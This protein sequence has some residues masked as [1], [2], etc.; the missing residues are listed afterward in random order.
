[1]AGKRRTRGIVSYVGMEIC[2][3]VR[4][5]IKNSASCVTSEKRVV[6]AGKEKR[7]YLKAVEP[8]VED[9]KGVQRNH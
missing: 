1:M 6:H 4:N 7:R 5:V 8:R 3:I 2:D 9:N